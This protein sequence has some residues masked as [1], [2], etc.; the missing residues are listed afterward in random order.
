MNKS[1]LEKTP[2][3]TLLRVSDD[4]KPNGG[5]VGMFK[6]LSKAG[7]ASLLI[8]GKIVYVAPERLSVH[9]G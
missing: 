1:D 2:G 4:K 8:G 6:K 7:N 3:N 9:H 5:K